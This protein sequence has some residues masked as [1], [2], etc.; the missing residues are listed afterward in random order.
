MDVLAGLIEGAFFLAV[1]FFIALVIFALEL[2]VVLIIAKLSWDACNKSL[3]TISDSKAK[4]FARFFIIIMFAALIYTAIP[5]MM[6]ASA[7]VTS[8]IPFIDKELKEFKGHASKA[9]QF[10]TEK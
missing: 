10:L 8:N 9:W 6:D 4:V 5:F 2:S 7:W 3:Q 1:F